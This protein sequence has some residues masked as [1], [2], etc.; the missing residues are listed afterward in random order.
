[1]AETPSN[2]PSGPRPENFSHDLR[3]EGIVEEASDDNDVQHNVNHPNDPVTPVAQPKIL[4]S[5]ILPP[6]ETPISWYVKSQGAINAVYAQ[7]CAQAAHLA[8]QSRR[9][10]P[11][12]RA[13]SAPRALHYD[14]P[15]RMS[16]DDTEVYSRSPTRYEST[17]S[18]SRRRDHRD[19]QY[20]H[21]RQSV[22]SWLG[23]RSYQKRD[24]QTD[25][26]DRTYQEGDNTSVFS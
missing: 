11:Q 13:P 7:L 19:E 24:T 4:I 26:Y 10:A 21:R 8:T 17:H 25:E 18:E 12:V 22:H 23:P 14:A 9:S 5:S 15:S 6:G 16:V 20:S 3:V 1:M 2:R